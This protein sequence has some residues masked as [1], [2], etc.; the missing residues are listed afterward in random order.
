MTDHTDLLGP[1]EETL[2]GPMS[3]V[4]RQIA[5]A[6]EAKA[7]AVTT[8]EE[9]QD[10]L[11]DVRWLN[12]IA[13]RVL[14]AAVISRASGG[15]DPGAAGY[16][17]LEGPAIAYLEDIARC[18]RSHAGALLHSFRLQDAARH[19]AVSAR[20]DIEQADGKPLDGPR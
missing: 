15:A 14:G 9:L 16:E 5:V 11:N 3:L 6:L 4:K 12:I 1:D 20:R 2:Y 13:L 8:S 17:S 19:A 7:R 10:V 18:D